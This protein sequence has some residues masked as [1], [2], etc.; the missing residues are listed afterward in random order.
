MRSMKKLSAVS[1][2]FDARRGNLPQ[3]IVIVIVLS[4]ALGMLQTDSTEEM[5]AYLLIVLAC[6]VPIVLWILSGA[7]SIPIMAGF[8]AMCFIYYG[9]PILKEHLTGLGFEPSE[10]LSGAATVVLFLAV[11]SVSW[12]LFIGSAHRPLTTA[13]QSVSGSYLERLV[14]LGL[15]LG[16]LY[17]IMVYVVGAQAWLG[18]YNG[19]VRAVFLS[20][21]TVAFFLAG[22]ARGLGL[23]RGPKW[24]IA[25]AAMSISVILSISDLLLIGGVTLC[26]SALFGYVFT[27]KRVP[28]FYLL[29]AA[30]TVSVLQAGKDVMRD[31]YS[32]VDA[33]APSSIPS[34]MV[35]W[36]GDGVAQITTGGS[37]RSAIDRASLMKLLLRSKRLAPDYVPFL[38]GKTYAVL[39]DMLVPRFFRSDKSTSQE[40][41]SMLNIH[42]GLQSLEETQKTAIGWGLISEAYANFGY[43]GVTGVALVLGLLTGFIEAWSKGAP[44]TSLPT[45]V[46]VVV[47]IRIINMESDAA[48]LVTSLFQ[49]VSGIAL[50]FWLLESARAKA[51]G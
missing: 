40:S 9:V 47:L 20:L 25:I 38:E 10:I 6:T 2:A 46:A 14:F 22:H 36:V 30:V 31:K 15:I 49:S 33:G 50:I 3:V 19:L 26:L 41:M 44:I 43:F 42:F 37:Y 32:M 5:I 27:T 51:T 28:W 7:T 13:R 11:A 35:E 21:A 4:V 48:S 23:L 17:N 16:I 1:L 29:A 34:L 8:S 18:P 45:V 24:V 12:W 39:P